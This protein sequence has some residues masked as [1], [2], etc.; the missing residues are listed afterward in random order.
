MKF[1]NIFFFLFYITAFSGY[2]QDIEH[3]FRF[4]E[5]NRNKVNTIITQTVSID[6]IKGDTIYAY[7][8][9][10]EF[11]ALLKLGYKVEMLPHPSELNAKAT[12]MATT[13]DEMAN[14]DRYPTYEVYRAMMKKFETD[15]PTLC[16][17][18]SIGTT[19]EGRKL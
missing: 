9:Q 2:S 13:I 12:V 17:L 16:K 14:W 1:K 7:A 8:N 5:S 6:N 3:Y 4:V 15:Y 10:Q 18:D 19:V 11:N